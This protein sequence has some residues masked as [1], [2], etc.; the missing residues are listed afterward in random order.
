MTV[1]P[2]HVV[3]AADLDRL[4]DEI[5]RSAA[6]GSRGLFGPDSVSWKINRE[7]G[8]FLAAG[9]ATLLQLAHPWVAAA[10]AE[11][12]ATLHDP[13]GR[14]HQT[15]RVMFTVSFG[16][17][18][19]AIAAAR[20]LHARHQNIH[21]TLPETAGAFAEGSRYEANEVHALL[22]V[23]ATLID[24]TIRAYDLILPAPTSEERERYYH[25]SRISASLLGIPPDAWPENWR[26][27]EQYMESMYLSD[28]LAVSPVARDLAR[29]ILSGAGSWLRIPS[30]YRALTAHLLPPRLRE[31]FGLAYGEQEKRSAER[32]LK[33]ARRFYGG[34]P[35]GV[36][37]VGPYWEALARMDG[38]SAPSLSVRLS[39]KL[40]V[41]ESTLFSP[42]EHV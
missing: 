13:I 5:K 38:K 10:I 24:S 26:H 25:E 37:F 7:A 33:C 19:Q 4:L 35:E 8:L 17:V 11:H 34:L 36:R 28:T 29:Q 21:G 32:A 1:C 27:F 3:S 40:W 30:W 14:F 41:G 31:E 2:S 18:E 6:G 15:F 39:N 23:Y 42:G 9:R 12:S 22:W 20:H 16:S